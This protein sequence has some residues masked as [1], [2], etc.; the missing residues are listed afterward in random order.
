[1]EMEI[2]NLRTQLD[3]HTSSS[4]SHTEQVSALEEKLERAERAAGAAQRELLDAR[5][6]LDRASEKAVKEGSERTSAEIRLRTLTREAEDSKRIA[7]ESLK[8][9]ETLEKKLATLTTLHKDAD[10]R[11]QTGERERE[12]LEK[13]LGEL[14]RRFAGVENENL[15]L[16]EERERMRKRDI[17]GGADDE[18]LD[19]LEDEERKRLEGRVRELEGEVFELRRGVWRER[20]RE[21]QGAGD[22][23]SIGSP[24]GGFDDVDLS[25]PIS[26]LRRPSVK[27]KP[28][29]FAGVLSSGFGAFTGGGRGGEERASM[30]L[31]EGDDDDF[32]EDAFRMAQEE[33][34]KRRVERIREVKRGLKDWEGWRMDIVDSRVGGGGAGEIFDV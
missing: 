21:L 32:D 10:A 30:D 5:K 7:E 9:V 8:R 17:S 6:N 33:E 27:G 22:E 3:K 23:A 34:G 1:M 13:D 14:R 31:M 19:E 29:G 26:P 20:K 24:S 12:R 16:R 18:G 4:S 25:G 28:Q 2:S 15:R 11:R